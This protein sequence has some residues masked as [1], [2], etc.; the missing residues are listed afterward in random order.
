MRIWAL[1]SNKMYYNKKKTFNNLGWIHVGILSIILK[2]GFC[3][4]RIGRKSKFTGERLGLWCIEEYV[5]NPF[6]PKNKKFSPKK[7][8]L[9]H[10]EMVGSIAVGYK[11][12]LTLWAGEAV[13]VSSFIKI[14]SNP[15][16]TLKPLKCMHISSITS[17]A[18]KD[19]HNDFASYFFLVLS[20][21]FY[22]F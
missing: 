12:T 13:G 6:P 19:S 17:V 1:T 22:S 15:L 2:V 21:N 20:G 7:W 18:A 16:N 5:F 4:N 9:I 8:W 14:W 10:E 3:N 11:K